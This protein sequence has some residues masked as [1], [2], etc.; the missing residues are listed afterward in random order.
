M[1]SEH[2]VKEKK[3]L[4]HEIVRREAIPVEWCLGVNLYP[5]PAQM[6]LKSEFHVIVSKEISRCPP[7][8]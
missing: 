8:P 5:F 1:S 7:L 2:L 3:T 4:E 6:E